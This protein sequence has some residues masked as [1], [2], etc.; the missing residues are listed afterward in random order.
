MNSL[1]QHTNLL[2][3]F[4]RFE[5][6]YETVSHKKVSSSDSVAIAIAFGRKCFLWYTYQEGGSNDACYLIG[7]DKDKQICSVEQRSCGAFPN[8]FCLGTVIY[9]TIYEPPGDDSPSKLNIA[10]DI[11]YY[12]GTN[13]SNLCFG[14]RIGFL[15]EFVQKSEPHTV[16]LPIM[17]HLEKGAEHTHVIGTIPERGHNEVSA[18]QS[19]GIGRFSGEAT[20]VPA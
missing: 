14:D 4:P 1:A 18:K 19:V 20:S 6:S 10:E 15:K 7:L 11:Y 12:C 13:L 2:K 5:L 16:S 3:R 8:R 9:C 17:W